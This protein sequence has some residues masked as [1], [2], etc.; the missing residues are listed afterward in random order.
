MLSRLRRRITCGWLTHGRSLFFACAK[1][2]G[3]KES[4]P[5][6]RRKL[7]ALLAEGGLARRH[8]PVPLAH[9]RSQ[10]EP[11]YRAAV[12]AFGSDARRRLRGPEPK[13]K[14]PPLLQKEVCF[15]FVVFTPPFELA[16]AAQDARMPR[17]PGMAESGHRRAA[18]RCRA[19]PVRARSALFSARRVRLAPGLVRSGGNRA[20]FARRATGVCFLLVPFLCT[21]KEKEPAVGQPPTSISSYTTIARSANKTPL[22]LPSP[23][24]GEG[25]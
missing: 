4:T 10:R 14:T 11:R 6:S 5:R 20:L 16:S 15:V 1:I 19:P 2:K 24:R 8:L 3:P 22:T 23:A 13:M 25:K 17:R 18:Q 9:S 7:P 21:S 12:S